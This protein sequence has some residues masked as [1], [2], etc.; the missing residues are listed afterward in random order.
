ML[1]VAIELTKRGTSRKKPNF[2]ACGRK[3]LILSNEFGVNENDKIR[4]MSLTKIELLE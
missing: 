3:Y 1:G 4:R 2:V